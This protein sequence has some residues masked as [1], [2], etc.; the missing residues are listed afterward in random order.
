MDFIRRTLVWINLGLRGTMELGIVIGLGYWGW[1]MGNSNLY[2]L[3]LC[4]GTPLIGFGF[5]G[6]VDFHN[7]RNY[8]EFLRLVQ[9]L[10]ISGLVAFLLY[11]IGKHFFGLV[12]GFISILYHS[13]VY[14]SGDRLLK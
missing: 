4:T 11:N 8:S 6:L 3:L 2:K 14:I 9:E 12:L 10:L 7:F 5:W 13:L 1:Y